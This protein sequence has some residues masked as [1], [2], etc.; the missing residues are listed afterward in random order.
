MKHF[1]HKLTMLCTILIVTAGLSSCRSSNIP[2]NMQAIAKASV[3]LGIDIGPKDNH[4][5]YIE[6][7]KWIGAPYRAGGKSLNG[8]DCSGLTTTIY[9]KVYGIK[10]PHRAEE[11]Q[12]LGTKK[13]KNKLQEGD[14]VFFSSN[15][16]KKRVAHAGIY[17]KDGKF[18]HASSSNGVIISSLKEDYYK[19]NWISGKRVVQ[20]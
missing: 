8:T 15:R 11:Q 5:L 16:T 17:L 7:A 2:A 3:K 13:D 9:Q 4:K 14:L 19:R 18:I 1:L 12:K 20:K 6:A 10:L